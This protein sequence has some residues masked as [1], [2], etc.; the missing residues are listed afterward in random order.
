MW[1]ESP[2][3]VAWFSKLRRT[4][5]SGSESGGPGNGDLPVL[6]VVSREPAQLVPGEPH[7]GRCRSEGA[8]FVAR[9]KRRTAPRRDKELR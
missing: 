7:G 9:V 3:R 6:V 8:R 2:L 4:S 1:V 5:S